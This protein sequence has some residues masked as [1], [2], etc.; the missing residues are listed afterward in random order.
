MEH[1]YETCRVL[2]FEHVLCII[3]IN[4]ILNNIYKS[5]FHVKFLM[6]SPNNHK[7]SRNTTNLKV[8]HKYIICRE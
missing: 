4:K 2:N 1:N 6:A 7:N 8:K 3:Y 5:I